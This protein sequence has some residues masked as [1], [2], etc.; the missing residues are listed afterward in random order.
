MNGLRGLLALLAATWVCACASS[1]P[2]LDLARAY[3]AHSNAGDV[4]A[5][6]ALFAEDAEWWNGDVRVAAGRDEVRALLEYKQAVGATRTIADPEVVA[7]TLVA[8]TSETSELTRAMGIED[9]AG[10]VRIDE[11]GGAIG[12]LRV[13][14]SAEE[15]A[16]LDARLR[17]LLLWLQAERPE[18]LAELD[19]LFR[20][21][22][23]APTPDQARRLV[24]LA[25]ACPT[26]E[27]SDAESP[28]PW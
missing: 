16:R 8:R 13:E 17:D 18:D 11:R 10:T 22:A 26:I 5:A 3:E 23:G 27:T 25:R 14:T 9:L 1:S 19:A 21:G 28:L 20:D 15:R 12:V 6:L 24:E 2:V 4:D 7:R